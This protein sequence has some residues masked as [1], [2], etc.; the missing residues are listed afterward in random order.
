MSRQHSLGTE[1][2]AMPGFQLLQLPET[3]LE[4]MLQQ[5]DP[6]D[7]ACMAVTCR[8]L[9]QDV[10]ASL[11]QVSVQW[12]ASSTYKSFTLLVDR[13][14]SILGC[15]TQ[16]SISGD[17]RDP[18]APDWVPPVCHSLPFPQ[19]QQ[20]RLYDVR[21]QLETAGSCAGVLNGCSGLTALDLQKC[22]VEDPSV[23]AFAS[24]ATALPQLQS[25]QIDRVLDLK[26]VSFMPEVQR[27]SQLTRLS[28]KCGGVSASDQLGQLIYLPALV[29]LES[30]VLSGLSRS[31]I[32]GGVPSELS[33]LTRLSVQHSRGCDDAEQFKHFSS[34]TALQDLVVG[35]LDYYWR[36]ASHTR[37]STCLS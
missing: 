20:L 19:L 14:S 17:G 15:I 8:K 9:S 24:I 7:L 34:L 31:G 28:I 11:R 35:S 2:E 25:L 16:C 6:C 32:P 37:F 5:L 10:P 13:H 22:V 27:L 26:G 23:A 30:L 36:Q 21:V 4:S 33:K 3:A 18:L 29:N 12:G 1:V